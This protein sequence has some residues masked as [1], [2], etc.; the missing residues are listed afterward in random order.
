V[1]YGKL[2]GV[3]FDFELDSGPPY[4]GTKIEY[5]SYFNNYFNIRTFE[6]CY[7]SIASRQGIELFMILESSATCGAG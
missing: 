3:L 4:G 7:N 1:P 5:E 6:T 2:S